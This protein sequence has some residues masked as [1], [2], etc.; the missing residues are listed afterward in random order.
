MSSK[1]IM[2]VQEMENNPDKWLEYRRN[3]VGGSEVGTILGFAPNSSLYKL[4][5]KKIN[6]NYVEEF[7]EETKEKFYFGHKN[8]QTVADAF[9]E[10]TGIKVKKQGMLQCVEK[11]FA[12]ANV[13]R[14]IVGLDE[15]GKKGFLECKNVGFRQAEYWE[16]D[17]VPSYYYLQC[18]W[19]CYVG[20][21]DYFY[22]AALIDGWH[23]VYKRIERNEEDIA[24]MVEAVERFWN[25]Y[26]VTKQAPPVDAT[27]DCRKVLLAKYPQDNGEL[28][29][30]DEQWDM[31]LSDRDRYMAE[32]KKLQATVDEIDNKIRE[33]ME[34]NARAESSTHKCSYLTS[35]RTGFDKKRLAQDHPAIYEKYVTKSPVRTLRISVK[36]ER[37]IRKA[38]GE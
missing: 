5:E 7:S 21:Y 19:Y 31:L 2:T 29:E 23:F 36:K 14:V 3:G 12:F 13:D 4:W 35:S 25:D 9:E 33:K 26:V 16:N 30:L 34:D 10:R 28:I 17:E 15:A 18:Q 38:I 20:G 8:E 11:P 24:I 6:P 37:K 1:L 32:I 27:D 22:I